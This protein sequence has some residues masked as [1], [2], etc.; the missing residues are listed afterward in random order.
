M[1]TS[2]LLAAFVLTASMVAGVWAKEREPD[3]ALGAKLYSA[4][5]G[6]CHN[7]RPAIE[8][9]DREWSIVI[10]HMRVVA[11]LPGDH[12]RHIEAFLRLGNNPARPTPPDVAAGS[13][14]LSGKD[15]MQRYACQGCHVV[16][17]VGGAAG[18]NL[19]TVFRRRDEMW[20]R[21]QIRNPRQH[22]SDT[23]MPHFGLRDAEVSAILAV[24]RQNQLPDE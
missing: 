7:Y 21:V 12:A 18:P 19:D 8:L 6:R 3:P 4:N 22:N 14:P 24:L 11:G 5:C 1:K 20:I 15:L 17:G 16:G 9:G 23:L 13:P 2:V 10:A